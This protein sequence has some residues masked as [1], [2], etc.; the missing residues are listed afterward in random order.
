MLRDAEN[1][2]G[3]PEPTERDKL[4][5]QL[6]KG[7][8]GEV[9]PKEED[10]KEEKEEGEEDDNEEFELDDDGEPK[11]DADGNKIKKA[12]ETAEE[13]TAREANETEDAKARRKE[14]RIQKRIDKAVA[15]Q[16]VAEAEVINL[17]KQLEAKP[18]D[19]KLTEAEVQARAEVIANEKVATQNLQNLQKEFEKNCDKI[20][21]GAIKVDPK[22][23]EKVHELAAELGPLPNQML[24]VLFD[25]EHGADVLAFLAN[26][27]DEAERIYG[28]IDKPARLGIALSKI[29]DKLA[30]AKRPKP[31]QISNVPDAVRPVNGHSVQS[32][33]ITSK[34]TTPAG[35]D[36]YV[37]KRQLQM[38]QRKKQ[39][40]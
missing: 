32:T 19:E 5:D 18:G 24:N 38:E 8:T 2:T 27:V 40:R 9:V 16:R 14:E 13:K 22:F 28:L 4:R 30:E 25:L 10:I 6:A 17:K 21:E 39:G 29:A 3:K 35:M 34:D 33:Q 12:I 20:Q 11:L 1:D 37:R 7:N 26:D 36:N 31:R 15:A 23:N